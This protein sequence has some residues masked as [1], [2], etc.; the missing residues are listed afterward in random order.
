L[1]TDVL[2]RIELV[3]SGLR[4]YNCPLTYQHTETGL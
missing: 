2:A 3:Q 1:S 4:G